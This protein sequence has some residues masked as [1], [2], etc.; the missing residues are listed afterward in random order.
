MDRGEW[1]APAEL[2]TISV[3]VDRKREAGG[4]GVGII[5]TGR[6]RKRVEP[7]FV[8]Q[9]EEDDPRN[10]GSVVGG[11]LDAVLYYKPTSPAKFLRACV[12]GEIDGQEALFD[13][14]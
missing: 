9:V 8:W 2:D 14:L 5:V 10:V 4:D 12:G 7:L 13:D 11:V 6:S 3:A 1:L